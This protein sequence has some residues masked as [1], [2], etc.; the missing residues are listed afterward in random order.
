[1]NRRFNVPVVSVA[2]TACLL[3]C[4]ITLP[5]FAQPAALGS[6]IAAKGTAAGAIACVTCHGA[7]GEGNA[8][9]GFPRLAGMSSAYLTEQLENFAGGKRQ[10]PVMA[11]IA[12][13]LTADERKAVAAYYGSLGA[14]PGLASGGDA[15]LKRSDNGAWLA[16]R[17]R[18]ED[19]L[20]ACVQCHGAA[21]AG[22]GAAFPALAGQSSAYIAAQLHAFKN[23]TRPGGPLNLM[24]VVA[25]K[26]SDADMSAVAGHFGRGGAAPAAS[27]AANTAAKGAK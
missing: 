23:G 10:N 11:P 26:L 6:T 20:P 18:W 22:V 9:A 16:L 13:Q 17:G 14:A 19:N 2:S 27:T 5:A 25:S 24:K 15:S 4:G 12:K 21:G 8:A 7:K 3:L 1:M